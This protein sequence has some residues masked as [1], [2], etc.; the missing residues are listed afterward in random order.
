MAT[1][2]WMLFLKWLARAAG[3]MVA[4]GF[5]LL[6]LGEMTSPHSGPPT[7]WKEWLGIV[8]I[9]VA[10]LAPLLAWKWELE[11]ALLSLAALAAWVPIVNFRMDR[12][13]G[14]LAVMAVPACLFLLDWAVRKAVGGPVR[15]H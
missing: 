1:K 6:M 10:C 4:G 15:S 8:L 7:H 14:T 3:V 2:W 12:A 9:T 11:A 5:L 13:G